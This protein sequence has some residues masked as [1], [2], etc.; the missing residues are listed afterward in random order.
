ML[1]ALAERHNVVATEVMT[2]EFSG[3]DRTDKRGRAAPEHLA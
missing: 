3:R 1:D 2:E